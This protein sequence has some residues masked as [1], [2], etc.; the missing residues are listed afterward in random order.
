MNVDE[1]MSEKEIWDFVWEE[2]L[3]RIRYSE[4]KC[5]I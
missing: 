3:D 5:Q 1:K 4:N 2:G